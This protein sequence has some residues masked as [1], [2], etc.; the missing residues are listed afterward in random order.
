[1]VLNLSFMEVGFS[2]QCILSS[3]E[4]GV[5]L[6]ADLVSLLVDTAIHRYSCKDVIS[7]NRA[8]ELMHL[9]FS[10]I[11]QIEIKFTCIKLDVDVAY[12]L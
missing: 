8:G 12:V 1:M 9:F 2:V 11:C 3:P 4:L 7:L 10:L 6:F 5:S